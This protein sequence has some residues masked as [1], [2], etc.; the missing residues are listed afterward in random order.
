MYEVLAAFGIN[1][2]GSH[3]QGFSARASYRQFAFELGAAVNTERVRLV[4]GCIW[5]AGFAIEN[6][7]GRDMNETGAIVHGRFGEPPDANGIDQFG[8]R[9]IA[10][11]SIHR[12]IGCR[13]ED[14]VWAVLFEP[15]VHM[16]RAGQI[17]G[18]FRRRDD[19]GSGRRHCLQRTA[20][21][22]FGAD[23]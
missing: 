7:I 18:R 8:G 23:H 10:F 2:G 12:G 9:R 1:P 19:I 17:A 21:L 14:H 15:A 11:R 5:L 22:P 6:E 13:V 3:D 16:I 20:E 4:V